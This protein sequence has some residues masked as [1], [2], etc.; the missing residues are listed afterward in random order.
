MSRLMVFASRRF[1]LRPQ[2]ADCGHK[3]TFKAPKLEN[4]CPAFCF[5]M[6][7]LENSSKHKPTVITKDFQIHY[8]LEFI[9]HR[10]GSNPAEYR[11]S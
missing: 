11:D 1:S 7:R 8:L 4:F 2:K 10:E 3:A 9:F 5:A 6:H